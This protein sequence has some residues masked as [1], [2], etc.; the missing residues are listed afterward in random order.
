[1]TEHDALADGGL[2]S[3]RRLSGRMVGTAVEI[4]QERLLW[5]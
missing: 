2:A 5:H 3:I 1:V 4:Q